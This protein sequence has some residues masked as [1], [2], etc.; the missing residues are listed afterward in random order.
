MINVFMFLVPKK[1]ETINIH[2]SFDRVCTSF[3]FSVSIIYLNTH[4]YHRGITSMNG[5]HY[6][7]ISVD[8]LVPG[9]FLKKSYCFKIIYFANIL[10]V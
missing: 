6:R 1:N 9:V 8:V 4:Y 2:I 10:L 7:Q 3:T 5:K